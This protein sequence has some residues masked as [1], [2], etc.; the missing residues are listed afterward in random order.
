MATQ[1]LWYEGVFHLG[2]RR[3]CRLRLLS[4]Q[5]EIGYIDYLKNNPDKWE[6]LKEKIVSAPKEEQEAIRKRSYAVDYWVSSVTAIS[7]EGDFVRPHC[8]H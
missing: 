4:P 2:F 7:E 1:L 3:R 8:S 6:N 5:E